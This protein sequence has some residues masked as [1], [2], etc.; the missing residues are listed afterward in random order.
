M[1]N[2]AVSSRLPHLI[3]LI[4]PRSLSSISAT[5]EGY[6]D[7]GLVIRSGAGSLTD[8]QVVPK[9]NDYYVVLLYVVF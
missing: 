1:N 2:H 4:V 3:M 8:R 6:V 9:C 7:Y 5:T